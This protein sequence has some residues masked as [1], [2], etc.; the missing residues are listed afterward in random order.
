[1]QG[2]RDT[3]RQVELMACFRWPEDIDQRIVDVCSKVLEDVCLEL[4]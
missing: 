3:C 2:S 4:A 1:M